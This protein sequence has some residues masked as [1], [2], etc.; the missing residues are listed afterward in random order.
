M[1]RCRQQRAS[2]ERRIRVPNDDADETT[3][4][5]DLRVTTRDHNDTTTGIGVPPMA[6]HYCR[7]Q[8]AP[9]VNSQLRRLPIDNSIVPS[10]PIGE[11]GCYRADAFGDE[12]T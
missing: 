6:C 5:I 10:V 2:C 1:L 3:R 11:G 12:R 4:T 8:S 9:S 7:N